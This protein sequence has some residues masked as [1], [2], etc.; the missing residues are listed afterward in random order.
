MANAVA[1]SDMNNRRP[2]LALVAAMLAVV[3]ERVR[4]PAKTGNIRYRHRALIRLE[5]LNAFANRS[6]TGRD[7]RLL[8][9]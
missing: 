6:V 9:V 3:V 1:V 2:R 5:P 4:L 7:A 8:Q